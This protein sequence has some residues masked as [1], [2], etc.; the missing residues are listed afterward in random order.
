V[1]RTQLADM[2]NKENNDLWF[3]PTFSQICARNIYPS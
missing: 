2:A 3:M 1:R